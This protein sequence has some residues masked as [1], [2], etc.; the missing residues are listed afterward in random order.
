M[1]VG[2]DPDRI[3]RIAEKWNLTERARQIA[4]AAPP[5]TETQRKL[6]ADFLRDDVEHALAERKAS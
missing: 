5:P 6:L 1:T 4:D 3:D 2:M